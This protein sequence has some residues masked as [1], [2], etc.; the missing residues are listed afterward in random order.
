MEK[1]EHLPLPEFRA[2]LERRKS[3]GEGGYK[4]PEGRSKK[5]YSLSQIKKARDISHDFSKL[6][7][8]YKGCLDPH[9]IF[10]INVNDKVD[11]ATFENELLKMGLDVLSVA[12]DKKGYWVVFAS[13]EQLNGFIS[14]LPEAIQNLR[15]TDKLIRNSFALLRVRLDHAA[16]KQLIELKEVAR[17]SNPRMAPNSSFWSQS[18]LFTSVAAEHQPLPYVEN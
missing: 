16:Y 2:D 5:D 18:G 6:K 11:T 1:L 10:E 13:D 9:L 7:E 12:E 15:V 8:Q 17:V 14:K 4:L 3:G